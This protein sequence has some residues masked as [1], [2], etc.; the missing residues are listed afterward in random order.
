MGVDS[1]EPVGT[2]SMTIDCKA[3]GVTAPT[4]SNALG[5]G[6]EGEKMDLVGE[7][8][9]DTVIGN[10]IRGN[11]RGN[12]QV[13]V[14]IAYSMETKVTTTKGTTAVL[15]TLA[16]ETTLEMKLMEGHLAW[17]RLYQV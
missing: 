13:L 12:I 3:D 17:H 11:S 9:Q 7:R 5:R 10:N 16:T 14:I 1:Y 8:T 15:E 2:K 4:M 6:T